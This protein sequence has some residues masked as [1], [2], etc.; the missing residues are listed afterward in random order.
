MDLS[1]ISSASLFEF[2]VM[3]IPSTV[4]NLKY[5]FNYVYFK[6]LIIGE[7]ISFDPKTNYFFKCSFD[8]VK[9]TSLTK[10]AV[11]EK[12]FVGFSDFYKFSKLSVPA[13]LVSEYQEDTI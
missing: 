12:T 4:Q 13:N 11:Y 6:G 10:V 8:D 9:L 5:E 1:G 7:N 2:G 3:T